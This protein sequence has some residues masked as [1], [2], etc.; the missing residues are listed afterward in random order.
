MRK[1]I[2]RIGILF[3]LICAMIVMWDQKRRF[4]QFPKAG[5]GITI[6]K[7]IGG[8]C[9]IILGRYNGILSPS[10]NYIHTSNV[11][12]VRLVQDSDAKLK[13]VVFN[14]L[15]LPLTIRS[16]QDNFTYFDDSERMEFTRIYYHGNQFIGPPYKSLLLDIRE[17]RIFQDGNEIK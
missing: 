2:L 3:V 4:V 12:A 13:I 15:G 17:N 6:W 16:T 11:N 8:K 9:Y 14:E 10:D 7:R 1:A 5:K